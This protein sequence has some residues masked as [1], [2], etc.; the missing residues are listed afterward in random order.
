MRFT[1]IFA[2]FCVSDCPPK[3]KMKAQHNG[4]VIKSICLLLITA[5]NPTD[6]RL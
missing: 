2:N 6:A 5:E 4:D 3:C 1:D